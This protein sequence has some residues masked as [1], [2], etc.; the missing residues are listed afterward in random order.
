MLKQFYIPSSTFPWR[1]PM[2]WWRADRL[3]ALSRQT[4]E[5][6]GGGGE[7]KLHRPSPPSH[8]TNQRR[9]RTRE[10][11]RRGVF[12]NLGSSREKHEIQKQEGPALF[13]LLVIISRREFPNEAALFRTSWKHLLKHREAQR[14]T[15]GDSG[16]GLWVCEFSTDRG[17]ECPRKPAVR[18]MMAPWSKDSSSGHEQIVFFS[19][20]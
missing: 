3:W 1:T 14:F 20:S 10:G 5:G 15:F 9:H 12:P 7:A 11:E 8:L 17:L 4:R 6:G 18:R 2:A 19:K 16:S 13:P